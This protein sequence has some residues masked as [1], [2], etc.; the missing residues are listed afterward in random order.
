MK[1]MIYI[2]LGLIIIGVLFFLKKNKRNNDIDSI[3]LEQ[4]SKGT[5]ID[6]T[7]DSPVGFGYKCMWIAV[8]SAE[9][10]KIA[11][12][13]GIDKS[14]KTNWK[15]GI[16]NAY[17]NSLFITPAIDGWTLIVGYGFPQE[18]SDTELTRMKNLLNQLSSKFG[19]AQYFAS[20]RVVDYHCWIKSIDGKTTRV[21][22]FIG[23]SVENIEVFGEETTIEQKYILGNTL[24]EEAKKDED[25]FL[26]EDLTYPDEEMVMEIAESWSINP[27]TLDQRTDITGLGI[28]GKIK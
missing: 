12:E 23:E 11:D 4:S 7:Q 27:T 25:Y 1:K 13:L 24:S 14:Q 9:Q 20:H 26:R 17:N 6:T 10:D 8:K 18:E 3:I 16:E 2:L 22:G 5:I 15:S 28:V 19:E 21:Y